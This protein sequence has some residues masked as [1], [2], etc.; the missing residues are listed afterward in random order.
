MK[1]YV[2]NLIEEELK[3]TV[4]ND[5]SELPQTIELFEVSFFLFFINFIK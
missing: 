1:K 2:D 3:V 4:K 5:T